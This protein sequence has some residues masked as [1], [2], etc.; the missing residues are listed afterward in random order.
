[1]EGAFSESG[2]YHIQE[3]T[4]PPTLALNPFSCAL[5]RLRARAL[6]R[7]P[8]RRRAPT[9]SARANAP[10]APQGRT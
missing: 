8:V 9:A 3:F 7:L 6:R 10:C 1:M 5:R 4:S 2:L